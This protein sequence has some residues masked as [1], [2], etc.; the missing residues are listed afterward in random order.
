MRSFII[1]AATAA[2]AG[3]S[4]ASAL[5]IKARA[6]TGSFGTALALDKINKKPGMGK[7]LPG[8]CKVG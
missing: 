5:H 1:G 3:L 8:Y 6:A 2:F 4:G 7:D